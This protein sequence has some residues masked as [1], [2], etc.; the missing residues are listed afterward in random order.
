MSTT[1]FPVVPAPAEARGAPA[2]ATAERAI[3]A[4]RP[5]DQLLGQLG[6]A[7]DDAYARRRQPRRWVRDPRL[8]AAVVLATATGM[9]AGALTRPAPAPTPGTIPDAPGLI[10]RGTTAGVAWGIAVRPCAGRGDGFV[11]S[12]LTADAATS[13]GCA[14]AARPVSTL[15]DQAANVALVF[16]SAPAGTA[17]VEVT[18]S[19]D[20]ESATAIAAHGPLPASLRSAVG[21]V[22]FVGEISFAQTATAITAYGAGSQLLEACNEQRCVAP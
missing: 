7:L 15:Y 20:G 5:V 13:T 1:E 4:A 22:L 21:V 6:G 2:P 17:R 3:G 14:P 12:L 8:L 19:G 11:V 18:R 9:L 16:G 10:A